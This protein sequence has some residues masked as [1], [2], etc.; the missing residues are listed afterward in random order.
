MDINLVTAAEAARRA[1]ISTRTIA[2]WVQEGRINRYWWGRGTRR[3]GPRVAMTE[4]ERLLGIVTS[5][6]RDFLLTRPRRGFVEI[7]DHNT[8]Q[9]LDTGG[10]VAYT[11]APIEAA[12]P[13]PDGIVALTDGLVGKITRN[14]K[15]A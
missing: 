3:L 11:D 8:G 7:R 4:V 9:T 15:G 13:H 5:N 12:V 2:R 1:G 6:G 14:D 10:A